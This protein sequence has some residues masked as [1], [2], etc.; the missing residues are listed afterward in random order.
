VD[1]KTLDERSETS[2]DSRDRGRTTQGW[3]RIDSI[4]TRSGH[5]ARSV[6]TFVGS[7]P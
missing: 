6:H 7:S 2:S 4:L 1:R 3:R 5:M